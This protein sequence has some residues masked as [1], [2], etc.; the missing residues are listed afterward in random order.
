MNILGKYETNNGELTISKIG[1]KYSGTYAQNGVI[2]G[3]LSENKLE[4]QW[5]NNGLE[6][7]FLFEFNEDGSFIGKYKKGIDPGSLRG[8]WTGKMVSVNKS[9][10]DAKIE[11]DFIL[12]DDGQGNKQKEYIEPTEKKKNPDPGYLAQLYQK[13]EYAFLCE[14]V[15][16]SRV[17]SPKIMEKILDASLKS[18]NEEIEKYCFDQWKLNGDNLW[19]TKEY[20]KWANV[21]KMIKDNSIDEKY[22]RNEKVETIKNKK[23]HGEIK[24]EGG[25]YY[26]GDLE[27]DYRN[28]IGTYYFVN[29]DYKEGV[30]E[31]D[32]LISGKGKRTNINGWVYEGEYLNNQRHGLGKLYNPKGELINDGKFINGKFEGDLKK[33]IEK[34]K[35]AIL[36]FAKSNG[37]Y[38]KSLSTSFL[39]VLNINDNLGEL[40]EKGVAQYKKDKYEDSLQSFVKLIIDSNNEYI[41]VINEELID[42][43]EYILRNAQ[44]IRRIRI[45][46]KSISE[47]KD[48]ST[49]SKDYFLLID[50]VYDTY[51]EYKVL[52][53]NYYK[54][55]RMYQD[56]NHFM[57]NGLYSLS[58]PI[59]TK[60]GVFNTIFDSDLKKIENYLKEMNTI[61]INH[62]WFINE[63]QRL[64]RVLIKSKNTIEVRSERQM[65]ENEKYR[66][67]QRAADE[68]PKNHQKQV[69]KISCSFE[70]T[71]LVKLKQDASFGNS[72]M[73][74]LEAQKQG[75]GFLDSITTANDKGGL[76][77]RSINVTHDTIALSTAAAKKYVAQFDRDIQKGVAGSSTI[78][79]IRIDKI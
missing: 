71:Y 35:S 10:G 1:D 76:R 30:W 6:G 48:F 8:K 60:T 45:K 55:W 4:G 58:R 65:A 53:I 46:D 27:G 49:F 68:K 20:N 73:A 63:L 15:D 23:H 16:K 29:G 62:D 13:E 11:D 39:K 28:G 42:A 44:K 9:E 79:I 22:A 3:K 72:L 77:E 41:S 56:Y 24:Y 57:H 43:V 19:K 52:E 74:T 67:Q 17:Y 7:L 70:I 31:N 69:S 2:S 14:C 12:D 36:E 47:D 38:N 21:R 32:K 37:F 26:R 78:K 59:E 61:E 18:E 33:N 64:E 34:L 25:D 75:R 40:Y 50:Q 66:K 54:V 5:S 51:A